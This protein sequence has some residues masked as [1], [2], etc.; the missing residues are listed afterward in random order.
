[1]IRIWWFI[2]FVKIKV[3]PF[4]LLRFGGIW[5]AGSPRRWQGGELV[6]ATHGVWEPH[7][8]NEWF[9]Q[10]STNQYRKV[11]Q[12][13]KVEGNDWL[14]PLRLLL[15]HFGEQGETE[16]GMLKLAA[17][18]KFNVTALAHFKHLVFKVKYLFFIIRG[19][20]YKTFAQTGPP[21]VI[22]KALLDKS[23]PSP[24]PSAGSFMNGP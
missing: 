1:M 7:K 3:G 21:F 23:D 14:F 9:L 2:A 4:G 18:H 10:M 16:S 24:P 6:F 8:S 17:N 13:T 5:P 22:S 19:H 20:S 15:Q 12:Y 11:W